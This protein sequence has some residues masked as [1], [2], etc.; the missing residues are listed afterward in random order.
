MDR[1][2]REM[3]AEEIGLM[4][5]YF[6][7]AE[8]DFLHLMGVDPQR[9]PTYDEWV[10]SVTEDL[11]RSVEDR[12]HYYL[13]WVLDGQ[14]VGHSNIN[15]VV[16][17]QEAFMHL[18]LWEPSNRRDGH[19]AYFVNQSISFYFET[20]ELQ[21]LFCEP[22]AHNPGPNKTLPKIGF[23]LVK[24]YETTPGWLNFHQPVNRWRLTREQWLERQG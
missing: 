22:N 3:R 2:V 14:P 12:Q 11:V 18:H 16:Y 23:E 5:S 13:T 4:V 19:G 9:L 20:F 10:N 24:S 17:G 6:R 21:N 8:L 7:D 1:Q 15:K